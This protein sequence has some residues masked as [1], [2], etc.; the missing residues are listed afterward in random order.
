MDGSD[1]QTIDIGRTPAYIRVQ[2]QGDG[3]G[4]GI[5]GRRSFIWPGN[6]SLTD[7]FGVTSSSTWDVYAVEHGFSVLDEINEADVPFSFRATF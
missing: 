7:F 1:P 2:S 3:A 6:S 5:L 4:G